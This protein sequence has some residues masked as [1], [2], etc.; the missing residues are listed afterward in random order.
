M[1]LRTPYLKYH[2]NDEISGRKRITRD[3]IT[4][5]QYE[6]ISYPNKTQYFSW[7]FIKIN[8]TEVIKLLIC[9]DGCI[10]ISAYLHIC[11][12]AYPGISAYL[13]IRAYLHIC[14]SAYPGILPLH[15]GVLAKTVKSLR[16]RMVTA[17]LLKRCPTKRS[18][19]Y[20]KLWSTSN[21]QAQ[22]TEKM[23]SLT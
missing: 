20:N 6:H 15:A 2:T 10:C 17:K 4:T 5:W 3:C 11:I 12:S 9:F 16:H 21:N 14:I 1:T 23:K 13:H 7:D 18:A 8:C 19:L 22:K